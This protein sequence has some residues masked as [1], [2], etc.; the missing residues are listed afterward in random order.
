MS[1]YRVEVE[2]D[3]PDWLVERRASIGASEVA[4]AVGESTY[5]GTP[6]Q[7][8]LSK[9]S[10]R[11]QPFDPMLSF[12]GH[13][14]EPMVSKWVE[15]FHPEVGTVGPGF[16]ARDDDYPW[17]HATFDRVVTD[18]HGVQVP[19]QL[20][21]S[22]TYAEHKWYDG[23]PVD[24]QIQE[25]IEC[26]VMGAPYALLAVWHHGTTKFELYKLPAHPER[27]A[28]LAEATCR[29][30]A[31]VESRTPPPPTLGDDLA[32][33]Y[34]ESPDQTVTADEDTLEAVRFLQETKALR[35]SI[36]AEYQAQEADAKHTIEQYMQDAPILLHPIT[37]Q[38][39]HTWKTNARGTR[40]HHTKKE[41]L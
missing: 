35:L 34:P 8:Y 13:E 1:M 25:E 4:A 17:L 36:V 10:A 16:M 12:I 20:K 27:Q 38:P 9:I 3:T 15:Q 31:H 37:G 2:P 21:T 30:W 19:L 18:P 32:A 23:V 7:V 29:L 39:I 22:S 33:L 5:G 24:Y 11:P 41:N 6:L 26:L 14:A 28:A 40:V